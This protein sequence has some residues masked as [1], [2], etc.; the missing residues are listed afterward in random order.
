MEDTPTN[1]SYH[2]LAKKRLAH[3]L[4]NIITGQTIAL[5]V[6]ALGA[7]FFCIAAIFKWE[8]LASLGLFLI[9]CW[10]VA[11][12]ILATIGYIRISNASGYLP[13]SVRLCASNH[14]F[15]P[16]LFLLLVALSPISDIILVSI[17]SLVFILHGIIPQF[18]IARWLA[19]ETED[20]SMEQFNIS[21]N[22]PC[23]NQHRFTKQQIY[24]QIKSL[25][26]GNVQ[27]GLSSLFCGVFAQ[28]FA[29]G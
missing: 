3:G 17:F 26:Y 7:L 20:G 11:S 1:D 2:S 28:R 10:F 25:S 29:A 14:I 27:S 9:A 15:I 4:R 19:K 5:Y 12:G 23:R 18:F 16:S 22:F 13:F 21:E 6:L 8:E 24:A